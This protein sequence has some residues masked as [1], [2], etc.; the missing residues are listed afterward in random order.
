MT[1]GRKRGGRVRTTPRQA[2][3][4][5]AAAPARQDPQSTSAM[6]TVNGSVDEE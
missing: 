6:A 4:G 1:E 5:C 3:T 2:G